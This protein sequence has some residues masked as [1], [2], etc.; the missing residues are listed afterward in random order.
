MNCSPNDEARLSQ[1]YRDLESIVA[2][3]V[4]AS[5]LMNLAINATIGRND[6]EF[7]KSAGLST[8]Q[9]PGW[10]FHALPPDRSAALHHALTHMQT[11]VK[12]LED[13]YFTGFDTEE[14]IKLANAEKSGGD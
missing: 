8:D 14:A 3:L 10:F 6:A 11:V 4:G 12:E 1:A 2:L 13:Q 9:L 7:L 5:E